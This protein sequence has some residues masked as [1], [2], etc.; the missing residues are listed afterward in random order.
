MRLLFIFSAIYIFN[1]FLPGNIIMVE[2]TGYVYR[3][4]V[5]NGFFLGY[6]YV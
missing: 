6:V 5:A 4:M 3:I 1:F 2:K